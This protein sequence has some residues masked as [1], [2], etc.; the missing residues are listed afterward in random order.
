ML[1]ANQKVTHPKFDDGLV[2]A[3]L[4]E[5][6]VVRFGDHVEICLKSTLTSLPNAFDCLREL[7]FSP[8]L[9]TVTHLQAL[10]IRSINDKWGVFGR[11]QIDLLPHQLWVCRQARSKK[12]CRLLVA[13]D[14]G[15]GKTIEAGII[16]SSFLSSGMV[17]RVLVLTPSS[18]VE[19]WQFRMRTMFDVRLTQYTAE[20]DT[21]R[22]GFWD[23]HNF[24]V[25]SFHTLR[26]NHGNRQERLLKSKPW[27]LV[28]VDEAHHFNK[29]EKLGATL[30]YELLEN[31]LQHNL[32]DSLIFFSGTPHKGKNFSFLS[33]MH[34]L[35]EQFVPE[36]TLE[37]Q[38]PLLKNYMIRNNKYNVTDLRGNRL[39]T[40]PQ[41]LSATYVYTPEEQVFY[42]TLTSFITQGFAYAKAQDHA[43]GSVVMLI[44][45]AM[46]KLA[47]SSV[48]AIRSALGRRL[49]KLQKYEQETAALQ[50]I[51]NT[52]NDA[53][54]DS[55]LDDRRAELE[56]EILEKSEF[57]S[58][59]RNE[60]PA[61]EGLLKLADGILQETKIQTILDIIQQEYA[62]DAILFFTEYKATQRLMMENLMKQ[63]GSDAVVMI[64]GDERLDDVLFPDG[65]IRRIAMRREQAAEKFNA[66]KCRFLIATEAAGE[67]IDLQENCHILFHVDLPW[68]PMRLH[69][70]V[71]R[72]NRYGQKRQVIVRNFRN[73]DTV[74]SRIWDKL[75][76]KLLHI[77][78]TFRSVM[79]E[80]EDIFQLVLGMTPPGLFEDLFTNAPN[81][82]E[83]LSEW[84]DR[85][86]AKFGD[87]DVFN[88]VQ[89]IAGNA[90][91]FNYQ[92]VSAF[93]PQVDLPDLLS[94][95]KNILAA[96]H[97]RLMQTGD[98]YYFQTPDDWR[99]F[100]ILSKYENLV[101]RRNKQ[102]DQQIVGIGAKVFDQA[103]QQAIGW[104]TQ[105]AIADVT[106]SL[107]IFSVRDHLTDN[108]S[109]KQS[110]LYGCLV[111]SLTEKQF[112]VLPDWK[113]LTLLNQ[114]R[115]SPPETGSVTLAKIEQLEAMQSQMEQKIAEFL[116][117]EC[118]RPQ[119]PL[120]TIEGILLPQSDWAT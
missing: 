97:K 77:D 72:L 104:K 95:M 33:L 113:L 93:L 10:S 21:S 27:D 118:F 71:G 105:I 69:Q 49:R 81:D 17:K 85:K 55:S 15:L 60:Q 56:E 8:I 41:V 23:I 58:L 19:Q 111:H 34:L 37:S 26:M 48:A 86:T 82:A 109:E 103:L 18:L 7:Q 51:L 91:K 98:T 53:L 78:R 79:E 106:S 35:S 32:I 116:S 94:F 13:D 45:I 65:S 102:R 22:S 36:N 101:F 54:T 107:L 90:D 66:G 80:K 40:E 29:D 30:A 99:G 46:Q 76:E 44:L 5:C 70:R 62:D 75:N 6:V 24:V 2:V 92:Q 20:Q 64:N 47:S 89:E 73:P 52:L 83:R 117:T 88:V 63:Y 39:F 16:I 110:S 31:M 42:D 3:D 100:G 59:I 115:L 57:I 14:V 1:H 114:L 28:I 74:E 25:A 112:E 84:F 108:V 4:G 120:F 119:R 61:I 96:N 38:L 11:S 9:E 50:G 87:Q 12:P 43:T 68:N 67:G